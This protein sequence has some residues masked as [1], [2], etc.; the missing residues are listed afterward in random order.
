M[1]VGDRVTAGVVAVDMDREEARLSLAPAENPKLWAFLS[2][3]RPGEVLSG[4]VAA[5]ERFG[6]FVALDDGPSHPLF[7]G[8]GFITIPEL[9]WGRIDS[10]ADVVQV[11]QRI[12]CEF[13]QF[14]TY[15]GEAHLSLRALRPDPFQAF[16]E[17]VA[18]G[19]T[20]RGPVTKLVPFGV[21]VRVA[22]GMAGLVHSKELTSPTDD[23]LRIGD[24]ITVAVTEIDRAQRRLALSQRPA[25][26]DTTTSR[27]SHSATPGTHSPTHPGG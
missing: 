6:V 10:A 24:E 19:Q 11:G 25:R 20:L 23:V 22:D 26:P 21:F 16:A 14:D 9:S 18:V 3:R 1:A 2:R 17:T 4:V 13:L 15:N 12:A 5:I 7:P 8:V 27:H